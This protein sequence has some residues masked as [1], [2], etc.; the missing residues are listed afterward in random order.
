MIYKI[1]NRYI[2]F[3]F[4][5]VFLSGFTS[6]FIVNTYFDTNVFTEYT[7]W[8]SIPYFLIFSSFVVFISESPSI[9]L[10]CD[11]ISDKIYAILTY[12]HALRL[13]IIGTI[14]SYFKSYIYCICE[15]LYAMWINIHSVVLRIIGSISSYFEHWLVSMFKGFRF[16]IKLV[17][18]GLELLNDATKVPFVS[19]LATEYESCAD[20]PHSAPNSKPGFSKGVL[21][22]DNRLG[23]GSSDNRLG[24]G[25][26]D[27][28]NQGGSTSAVTPVV[29]ASEQASTGLPQLDT[30]SYSNY[31]RTLKQRVEFIANN[32][33]AGFSGNKSIFMGELG[34][35]RNSREYNMIKQAGSTYPWRYHNEFFYTD[36]SKN[37]TKIIIHS[38]I[39]DPQ[40]A[41]SSPLNPNYSFIEHITNFS[42]NN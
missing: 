18:R 19:H 40:Y 31:G 32:K 3:K 29:Q 8:I 4:S 21:S 7:T 27:N 5:I 2:I 11:F 17:Y 6:R 14:Y 10:F 23:A 9:N 28:T 22:M 33:P 25:F 30:S 13:N 41:G 35:A 36:S 26:S 20:K 15:K 16:F 42:D 37:W 34:I 24:A 38:I 12:I 39:V 1:F